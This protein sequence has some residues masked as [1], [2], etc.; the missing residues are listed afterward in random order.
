VDCISHG[1]ALALKRLCRHAGKRFIPLRSAGIGSMLL[2][3]R[4]LRDAAPAA[5][6]A[7]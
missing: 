6:A 7:D 5:A 2:A 3:L 4:S 1:A